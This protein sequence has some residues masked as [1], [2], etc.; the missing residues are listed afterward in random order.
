MAKS[1]RLDANPESRRITVY[2]EEDGKTF[3]ET[4]QDCEGIV[5]AAKAMS[6]LPHDRELKPVALIPEAVLNRA[7]IEG[8][9]HDQAAWRRWANDPDNRDFRI[10]TGRL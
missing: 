10:T 3:V 6:E 1:A 4:R 2:H 8:W 9:F 5:N 7:F